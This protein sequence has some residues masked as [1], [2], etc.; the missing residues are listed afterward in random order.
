MWCLLNRFQYIKDNLKRTV[1]S[2][3][4]RLVSS[5]GG[6]FAPGSPGTGIHVPGGGIVIVAII[7]IIDIII[8]V[9]NKESGRHEKVWKWIYPI[10]WDFE[11]KKGN[12][13]KKHLNES[14]KK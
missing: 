2:A 13:R 6:F 10:Q 5:G 14:L 3:A 7:I 11:K 1:V 8:I 9:E 12:R 4:G